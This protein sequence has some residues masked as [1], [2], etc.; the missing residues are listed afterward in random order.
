MRTGEKADRFGIVLSGSLSVSTYETNGKR[1][2]IKLIRAPEAVAA[3]Q[4]LSGVDAM[5]VDVEANENGE[6]CHA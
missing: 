2:L 3:A 1:T 5:S 4:A 6:V